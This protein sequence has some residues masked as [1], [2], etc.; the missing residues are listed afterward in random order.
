LSGERRLFQTPGNGRF[1][2]TVKESFQGS[3]E[4]FC[5]DK[6]HITSLIQSRGYAKCDFFFHISDGRI[7]TGTE[8]IRF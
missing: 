7:E 3:P 5:G 4:E 2:K 1:T 8:F 6:R